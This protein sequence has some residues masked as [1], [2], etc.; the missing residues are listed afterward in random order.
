MSSCHPIVFSIQA[1]LSLILDQV[2]DHLPT[3]TVVYQQLV[4]KLMYLACGI[5]PDIAFII[6]QLSRHNSDLQ[7][8][9]I[10]IAKQT[11]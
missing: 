2:G 10:Y 11:L 5:K 9:Y 1:E 6:K 8:G 4:G 3:N 7:A